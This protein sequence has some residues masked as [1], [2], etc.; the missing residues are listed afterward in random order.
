MGMQATKRDLVRFRVADAERAEALRWLARR[1]VW[2]GRL[3]SLDT[4]EAEPAPQFE[5]HDS[6]GLHYGGADRQRTPVTRAS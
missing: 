2:E 6:G 5:V 1:P 3:R 4:R